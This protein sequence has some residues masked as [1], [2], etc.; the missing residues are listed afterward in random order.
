MVIILWNQD[1]LKVIN[2]KRKTTRKEAA[3]KT[4]KIG[5]GEMVNDRNRIGREGNR[6]TANIRKSK[7]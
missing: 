6:R 5:D 1:Y 3:D 4:K 2:K 7:I